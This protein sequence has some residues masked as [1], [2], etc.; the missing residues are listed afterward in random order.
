MQRLRAAGWAILAL[1]AVV[2][3]LDVGLFLLPGPGPG[4]QQVPVSYVVI[5]AATWLVFSAIGGVVLVHRPANR[6]GWMLL[7]IG[8]LQGVGSAWSEVIRLLDAAPGWHGAAPWLLLL[9]TPTGPIAYLLVVQLLMRFPD[10]E[11]PSRRW[12]WVVWALVVVACAVEADSLITPA[13]GLPGL[14]PSPLANPGI[15]RVLDPLT[16]FDLVALWFAIGGAVLVVRFRSGS[17]V[18][19]QQIKWFGLGVAVLVATLAVNGLGHAIAPQSDVQSPLVQVGNLLQLIGFDAVPAAIAVAVMRHRLFDIDLVI[20]RALAYGTLAATATGLYVALVVGIGALLGRTAGRDLFLSLVATAVVAVLFQ[21]L[22]SGLQQVANRLVYGRRQTPYDSLVGFTRQLADSYSIERVLP[23]MAEAVAVGTRGR[24]A[25]VTLGNG[26]G[27][28]VAAAWPG[29]DSLPPGS[30]DHSVEVA[31]Q[32]ER[33]GSLMVW[34]YPGEG[35]NAS[36][37]HLLSDLALQAG[38]VVHNASLTAE[39]ERRLEELQASRARLVSAQD[40]ERRRL[41][42]DLHDGAQHDLVA[43]RMKLGV[44]QA[45]AARSSLELASLISELRED[46]AAALENVRRLGR[47]LYPPL[48]ESQGLAA[49]LTAHSRRLPVP[50]EVRATGERFRP[51]LEAAVYFCCVEA[52]QNTVKHAAANRA[53]ITIEVGDEQLRFEVGDDGCGIDEASRRA[54]SGLQ[55]MRDRV[56]ALSGAVSVRSG[57]AGTVVQ[58]AMLTS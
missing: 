7:A 55:N 27:P 5:W 49:A 21:P 22:R 3:G 51:D 45:V 25:A 44:A 58:G 10:G 17:Q 48:L 15:A 6:I 20:S 54:G 2:W 18:V 24:A 8:F 42:R 28:R 1:T 57:P 47:G 40:S 35:L 34:T 38:L 11:L 30:P 36:E 56:E 46:S 31:H 26:G 50:V 12:R 13:P 16:S 29:A 43:L 37:R 33:L 23:R 52:L 4:V 53:W 39:L 32:G 9:A 41:E 14:P 19:R